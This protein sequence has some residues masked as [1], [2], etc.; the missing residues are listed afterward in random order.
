[1]GRPMLTT[2]PTLDDRYWEAAGRLYRA[3]GLSV[4]TYGVVQR[5][6]DRSAFRRD[7]GLRAA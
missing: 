5:L 6:L 4:Q 1:M 7:G 2:A 3:D